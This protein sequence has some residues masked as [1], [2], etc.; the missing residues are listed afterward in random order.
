MT[1]IETMNAVLLRGGASSLR[2]AAG[3]GEKRQ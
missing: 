2:S 1:E 3:Y